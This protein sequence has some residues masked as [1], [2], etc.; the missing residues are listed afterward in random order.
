MHYED[1]TRRYNLL[2]GAL[3]GTL[4]GSGFTLLAVSGKRR[5]RGHRIRR[6]RGWRKGVTS[7]VAQAVGSA[8][9]RLH[10]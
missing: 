6:S 10:L 8:R 4:L 3:L 9:E 2:S 5:W 7:G 1:E